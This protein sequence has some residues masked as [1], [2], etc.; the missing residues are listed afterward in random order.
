MGSIEKQEVETYYDTYAKDKRKQAVNRRHRLIFQKLKRAG[1]RPHHRLLEIGCGT[2]QVTGLL[3]TYLTKGSILA[4]DISPES[5]AIAKQHLGNHANVEFMVSDMSDFQHAEKFDFVL[6]PDVLEHIPEETHQTL[7]GTIARHLHPASVIAI[8]FPYPY[9]LEW[10]HKHDH[11][12]LQI[13][14]QPLY[15]DRLLARIY[16]NDLF[17]WKLESYSIRYQVPEYQWLE[18]RPR[19]AMETPTPLSATRRLVEGILARF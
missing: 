19:V 7:F 14:D 8:N 13:I 3:A 18:V 1:L 15:T 4:L 17:L 6:L 5:V 16:A 11:S 9:Y 10:A 2:G 12:Q